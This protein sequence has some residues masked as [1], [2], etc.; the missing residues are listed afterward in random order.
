MGEIDLA[1]TAVAAGGDGIARDEGGRVVF[2]EGA[3][4]GEAVRAAITEEKSGYAR[5]RLIEVVAGSPDRIV[6]PCPEVDRGCGGCQWQHVDPEAQARL[7]V[8]VVRD[9][10]RRIAHINE[11]PIS[12]GVPGV[13]PTGYRTTLRLAVDSGRASYRRRHGHETV[14]VDTCLVADPGLAEL[15]LHVDF[16]PK[17]TDVLARVGARTGD[18]LLVA[19]PSLEGVR[20]PAGVQVVGG[21]HPKAVRKAFISEIVAGRRWRVS[22]TSF[23]QSGPEAAEVLLD[24]VRE[25]VGDIVTPGGVILDAYCGVGILGGVLAE[26]TKARV[27]GV[28]SHYRSVSDAR[29]NLAHLD[30]TVIEGE[31]AAEVARLTS[32]GLGGEGGD[33]LDVVVADPARPGLGK[34][35]VSALAGLAAPRIVLAS[36]DPAS[37]AR[38]VA[39]L[40]GHGYA[41][42][43]LRVLDLFPGTF[44]LEAVA[45]FDRA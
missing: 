32:A 5:A 7:K 8:A 36:C 13:G 28:E 38:D 31:V 2:V 24:A 19:L 15:V 26:E 18:R 21:D 29:A 12:A 44:H 1:I 27:L 37:L 6:P 30:A 39:L 35:A 33:A 40:A 22:A 11:A 4:P 41:L 25:A 16:G 45:R 17:A 23:F 9:A 43:S 20:A 42:K 10:L 34:A 3:L 14:A